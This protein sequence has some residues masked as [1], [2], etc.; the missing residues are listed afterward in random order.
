MGVAG[1]LRGGMQ[2]EDGDCWSWIH[3]RSL[4]CESG[5]RVPS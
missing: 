4:S 5:G 1:E 3:T 2:L